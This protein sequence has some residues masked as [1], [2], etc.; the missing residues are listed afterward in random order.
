MAELTIEVPSLEF[1]IMMIGPCP[2]PLPKLTTPKLVAKFI[3]QVDA[4]KA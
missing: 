1:N 2:L 4:E 3:P